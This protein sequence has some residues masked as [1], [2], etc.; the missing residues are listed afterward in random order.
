MILI[1]F[2][3]FVIA[4][5]FILNIRDNYTY[6]KLPGLDFNIPSTCLFKNITGKNCPSCGMTRSFVSISH[7]DFT[8]AMRYNMAGIF[9]YTWCVLEII[10]RILRVLS[11]NG[12]V[13]LK[14]VRY[15]INIIIV[16]TVVVALVNWEIFRYLIKW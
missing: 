9:A 14:P 3:F 16:I 10:Y 11:K 15:L 1:L 8:G 12:S 13:L 5:S 2:L 4:C 7:F 6:I